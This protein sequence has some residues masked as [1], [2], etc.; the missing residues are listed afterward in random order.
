MLRGEAV[1]T[2]GAYSFGYPPPPIQIRGADGP[3][4]YQAAVAAG[5]DRYYVA[6]ADFLDTEPPVGA[7]TEGETLVASVRQFDTASNQ[8]L[9]EVGDVFQRFAPGVLEPN[10]AADATGN[11]YWIDF[12]AS[13]IHP[14]IRRLTRNGNEGSQDLSDFDSAESLAVAPDGTLY[15]IGQ[16]GF[17]ESQLL[18]RI[19]SL[20]SSPE[21]VDVDTQP[22]AAQLYDSLAVDS[23]GRL[24]LGDENPDGTPA[25]IRVLP[26]PEQTTLLVDSDFML[27]ADFGVMAL[28]VD[29][30]GIVYAATRRP[31]DEDDIIL[32]DMACPCD[33]KQGKESV[34]LINTFGDFVRQRV[35]LTGKPADVRVRLDCYVYRCPEKCTV[36]CNERI[37][38]TSIVSMAASPDGRLRIVDD[39]NLGLSGSDPCQVQVRIVLLDP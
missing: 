10:V 28:A 33:P 15:F 31:C 14:Q 2:I 24:L 18:F 21:V 17:D 22:F 35:D 8:L 20:G 6:Y 19:R 12:P 11:G 29:A 38:F 3:P 30:Q 5:G 26:D 36:G 34:L 7:G 39:V 23:E 25:I 37:P 1:V 13:S 16:R 27:E 32:D 4:D 9:E